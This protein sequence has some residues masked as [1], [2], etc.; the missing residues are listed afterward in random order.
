MRV[1]ALA[2]ACA[3]AGAAWSALSTEAFTRQYFAELRAALPKGHKVRIVEP[4]QLTVIDGEGGE[5]TVYLDN[6]YRQYQADPDARDEIIAAHVKSILEISIE[7]PLVPANIVPVVKDHAWLQEIAQATRER[8][9]AKPT[10]RVSDSLNDVLA[11]VYAEDTPTN[12]RYFTPEDLRKAGVDRARLRVLAVENLRRL[13]PQIEI[14]QGEL[15]SM[16]SAG[17]TYESS[18]LLLDELWSGDERLQVDGDIVVALPSRDVLLFT[19][20]KNPEGVA[21]MREVAADVV[22]EGAYTLTRE[23]FIH[24]DGKFVRLAP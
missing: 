20:S 23:L 14:A 9:D 21:R 13:L 2:L 8:S 11:I 15:F 12:I 6:A 17:G 1:V 4:L 7:T 22:D 5:S 16:I 3:W 24:R 19:G 18:L 10:E